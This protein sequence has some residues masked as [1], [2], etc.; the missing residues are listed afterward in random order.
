M[1]EH[2]ARPQ[3][4]DQGLVIEE[5][6]DELLVYDRERDV[7]HCLGSVAAQVWRGCDGE[8]DIAQIG[9]LVSTPP[10]ERDALV[11]DALAEL[12]EKGLLVASS[13]AANG[14]A[15]G[16]SRRQVVGRMAGALVAAPLIVSVVAPTALAATSLCQPT[17]GATC[18]QTDGCCT[19]TENCPGGANPTCCTKK[20]NPPGPPGAANDCCTG[21]FDSTANVCVESIPDGNKG[22]QKPG[23]C[24]SALMGGTGTCLG[25]TPVP[26]GGTCGPCIDNATTR[27]RRDNECC[28]GTTC[29]G[30]GSA[31]RCLA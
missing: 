9:R 8:R 16:L 7:A 24:A 31:A 20:G 14:G 22:C 3:A 10:D 23:D 4:R 19:T 29:Q 12:Q 28:A 25:Q 11:D 13:V 6:G 17:H 15:N 1:H 5:L 26:T 27:C 21:T 2:I 30:T 18:N